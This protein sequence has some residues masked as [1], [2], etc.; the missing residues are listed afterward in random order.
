V[1]RFSTFV[2]ALSAA[3]CITDGG[4][5]HALYVSDTPLPPERLATLA[6]YVARV[7]GRDVSSLGAGA[8]ELLP[9]CHLVE[10]PTR[11]GKGSER[12]AVVAT[13]GRLTFAL[14]MRAGHSYVIDVEV[15]P[16]TAPTGSLWIR[17]TETDAS[18]ERTGTFT[19]ASSQDDIDACERCASDFAACDRGVRRVL[20]SP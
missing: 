17:A 2:L 16:L 13:T 14:P 4:K 3:G 1:T 10:T 7:D 19:P 15:G 11:W 12:G 6:G 18:G 9:G 5:V 8:F 20:R